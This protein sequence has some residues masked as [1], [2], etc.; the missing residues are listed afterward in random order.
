[1]HEHW[2][3]FLSDSLKKSKWSR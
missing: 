3:F 1:M 2:P